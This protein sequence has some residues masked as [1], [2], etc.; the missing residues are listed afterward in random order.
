MALSDTSFFSNYQSIIGITYA[1]GYDEVNN[2]SSTLVNFQTGRQALIA[3]LAT[4]EV[5]NGL[6]IINQHLAS[7][8]V[9]TSAANNIVK[10]VLSSVNTF[11]YSTYSNYTRDYFTGLSA[12]RRIA[13]KNS[14]KEAWYQ[15]NAQELVQQIGFATYTGSAFVIYP[16]SSSVNNTQ[17]Y[18][19]IVG[20]SAINSSVTISNFTGPLSEFAL[21]GYIAIT[22]TLTT[23]PTAATISLSTTVTGLANT[24]TLYISGPITAGHTYLHVFRPLK[25]TEYL[26]FRFGTAAATGLAAT[27]ILSTV[28]FAVTLSSGVSTTV[29]LNTS[30]TSGRATIGVYN[31]TNYK[32]TNISSMSISTGSI[33]G[34]G[35]IPALEIWVKSTN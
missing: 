4:S 33:T 17:S 32:A 31:N 15:A 12:T 27:N 2:P 35:T 25:G 34:L 3:S 9:Y 7:E 13:W 1:R 6:T 10:S 16:A 28:G 19:T 14:F 29:T 11:F 24:N 26:E 23:I 8:N 5:T 22:S 21:P 18:A 20:T 30:S